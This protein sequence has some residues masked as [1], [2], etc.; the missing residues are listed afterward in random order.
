M[1]KTGRK[2]KKV[3]SWVR[4][5]PWWIKRG[6]TGRGG[7]ISLWMWWEC[8]L[9]AAVPGA[10]CH[11]GYSLG[12]SRTE[13]KTGCGQSE[14][15]KKGPEMQCGRGRGAVPDSSTPGQGGEHSRSSRPWPPT[16]LP[17]HLQAQALSSQIVHSFPDVAF[18]NVIP[19]AWLPDLTPHPPV[20]LLHVPDSPVQVPLL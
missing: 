20:N 15:K 12:F 5:W 1:E 19:L 14:W 6:H 3:S 10:G 7:I 17:A 18:V 11:Q 8:T 13:V 4:L 2:D 16:P 9:E